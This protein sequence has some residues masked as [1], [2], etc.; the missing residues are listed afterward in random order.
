MWGGSPDSWGS[1]SEGG[2]PSDGRNVTTPRL[3][4][5]GDG[6]AGESVTCVGPKTAESLSILQGSQ[7]PQPWRATRPKYGSLPRSNR[8]QGWEAIPPAAAPRRGRV[9]QRNRRDKR[10]AMDGA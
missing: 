1:R 2:M 8:S 3:P 5:G 10:T 7:T 4:D 6:R 9:Q